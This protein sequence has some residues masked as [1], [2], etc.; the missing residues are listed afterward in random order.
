MTHADILSAAM[1]DAADLTGGALK[2]HSPVDG[3]LIGEVATHSGAD[4]ERM[5]GR[6][7]SAFA[8]WKLVPAPR[9]GQV[10]VEFAT[11]EQAEAAAAR[12]NGDLPSVVPTA[13]ITAEVV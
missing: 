1:L 10:T 8:D 2:V 6:A 9:R 5:I 11:I 4:V 3:G 7:K 13:G 12:I